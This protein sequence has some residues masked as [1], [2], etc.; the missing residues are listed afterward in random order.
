MFQRNM[1]IIFAL[2]PTHSD[3]KFWKEAQL[4]TMGHLSAN[5]DPFRLCGLGSVVDPNFSVS[6]L[7]F[8]LWTLPFYLNKKA[9]MIFT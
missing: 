2:W 1:E 6:K 8:D 4:Q 7:T 3:L 5:F 9:N